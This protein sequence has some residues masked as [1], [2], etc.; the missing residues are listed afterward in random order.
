MAPSEFR[1]VHFKHH[2][3]IIL[4]TWHKSLQKWLDLQHV[5]EGS[6]SGDEPKQEEGRGIVLPD[7]YSQERVKQMEK[8]W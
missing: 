4:V 7:H 3:H 8:L 5:K 1:L 6:T 2:C